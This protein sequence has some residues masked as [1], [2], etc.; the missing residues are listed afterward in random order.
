MT[1][2]FDAPYAQRFGKPLID[3]AMEAMLRIEAEPVTFAR[4]SIP[5]ST[6]RA[7]LRI[8]DGTAPTAPNTGDVWAAGGKMYYF[9]GTIAKEIA[10]V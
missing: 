3:D 6:A 10:F 9:N 8:P 1:A 7:S 2:A 4:S 5:G